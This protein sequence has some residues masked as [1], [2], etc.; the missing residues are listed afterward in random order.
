MRKKAIFGRRLRGFTLVEAI[1]VI[2]LTGILAS[3]VARFIVTPVQG[4]FASAARAELTDATDSALRRIARDLRLALPNSVRIDASGTYMELL[5]TKTGGRYLSDEDAPVSGQI[6]D[7]DD[8]SKTS[9]QVVGPMPSGPLGSQAITRGDQIVVYNLGPGFSPADAYNCNSTCNRA[10]V[11]AVDD[12]THTIS[13]LSNPFAAQSPKF[14]SPEHHFQVVTTPVTYVCAGGSLTR[15]WGYPIQ[16]TQPVNAASTP[17]ASFNHA[18][19][20]TGVT[21]CS[22]SSQSLANTHTGLID[23]S[24]T[25][26]DANNAD[27]GS[28][29]LVQQVHVDNT[30]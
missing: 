19:L 27:S 3:V 2:A 20:A 12:T 16:A 4:Y 8:A 29:T 23:L 1:T 5:L 22:F 14:K 7:F 28:V 13:L 25:M 6:L 21:G 9:F 26:Q 17:L 18:L 15:Y 10:T 11:T 24:L 30:P